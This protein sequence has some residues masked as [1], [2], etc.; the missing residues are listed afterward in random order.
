MVKQTP[1]KSAVDG[2]YLY[3]TLITFSCNSGYALDTTQPGSN[4]STVCSITEIGVTK[5]QHAV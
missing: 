3:D 5:L 4:S 2:H 1:D